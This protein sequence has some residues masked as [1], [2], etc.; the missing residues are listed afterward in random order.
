M[1]CEEGR[2]QLRTAVEFSCDS[3]KRLVRIAYR[4]VDSCYKSVHCYSGNLS[5]FTVDIFDS[6]EDSVRI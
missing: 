1:E 3:M 5:E 6:A 4:G 2:Q